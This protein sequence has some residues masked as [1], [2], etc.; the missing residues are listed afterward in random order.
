MDF[1]VI[2]ESRTSQL[3]QDSIWRVAQALS[4]RNLIYSMFIGSPT[5]ILNTPR[6]GG[7][8]SYIRAFLTSPKRKNY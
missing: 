4:E 2:L 6:G 1:V 8:V 3:L 5:V 7:L